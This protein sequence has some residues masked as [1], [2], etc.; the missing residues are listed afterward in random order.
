MASMVSCPPVLA[1]REL[2]PG[3]MGLLEDGFPFSLKMNFQ[4]TDLSQ[5]VCFL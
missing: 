2:A 4:F 3:V 5:Q 1:E